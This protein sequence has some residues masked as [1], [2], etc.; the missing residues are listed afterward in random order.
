MLRATTIRIKSFSNF[1][2]STII[3]GR[4]GATGA[5]ELDDLLNMIFSTQE[6]AKFICR[7]IYSFFVYYKIDDNI[8]TNIITPLSTVFRNSG[9][10]ISAVLSVLLKSDHFY[11]LAYS[12]A[13]LIKSPLDFVLG[14]MR[15]FQVKMPDP[16][17]Y[18]SSYSIW[19]II[20]QTT[21]TLQQEILR[22]PE[23]AGW[24]AYY[25]GTAYHELWINSVT[26]TQRNAFTDQMITSGTMMNMVPLIIDPIAFASS[27]ANPADPN[28][29]IS[30]SLDILYRV[31]ISAETITSLKQTI[32]LGGLT[33]DYY[34]TDA[35]NAY[36]ANPTDNVA[37]GTVFSRLQ[38]MYKYL[39]N[40]P[41]YHLS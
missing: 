35:W 41:E 20:L 12:S 39:M 10:D 38:T 6:A 36:V 16:A 19:E 37:R 30:E 15:E 7:Q 2:G 34:W 25:Q 4:S 9:Y 28:L 31:P 24:Y 3:T 27:L 5:G 26:Y 11:N 32:L 18:G 33:T 17:D 21:A 40:L 13:C 14:L 22:I 8:E 29:L 23:V 1:Y